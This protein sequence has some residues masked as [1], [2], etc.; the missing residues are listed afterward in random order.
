[1]YTHTCLQRRDTDKRSPPMQHLICIYAHHTHHFFTRARAH[2]HTQIHTSS[3]SYRCETPSKIIHLV[4][5]AL[6]GCK[7]RR[8]QLHRARRQTA[9]PSAMVQ[10]LEVVEPVLSRAE[11]NPQVDGP[12]VHGPSTCLPGTGPAASAPRTRTHA[13]AKVCVCV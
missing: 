7:G 1:M 9:F 11:V 6:A 10:P 3:H 13:L 8:R 5:G 2:T 12:F 4:E